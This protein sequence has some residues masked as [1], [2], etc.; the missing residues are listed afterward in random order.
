[1]TVTH[2]FFSGYTK[3]FADKVGLIKSGLGGKYSTDT[4]PTP[5]SEEAAAPEEAE[6]EE[7]KDND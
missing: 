6:E 2:S 4:R 1:M 7:V 3:T 5:G